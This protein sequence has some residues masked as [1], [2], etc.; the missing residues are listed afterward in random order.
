MKKT[1]LLLTTLLIL[2]LISNFTFASTYLG[3]L[4]SWKSNSDCIYHYTSSSIYVKTTNLSSSFTDFNLTYSTGISQ[5]SNAG[6]SVQYSNSLSDIDFYGGFYAQLKP[7][8][9]NLQYNHAGYTYP[10]SYYLEG[11]YNLYG[12]TLTKDCGYLI[13]NGKACVVQ[14]SAATANEYR[15]TGVHELGHAL[16][17]DGHSGT[18]SDVMYP[19]TD[20]SYTLTSSEKLH[21]TQ[22]Y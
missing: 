21:L 20:S 7:F 9:P 2:I 8:F 4:Y 11:Y 18:S 15:H 14:R 1:K 19:T 6:I 22:V 10:G 5:W 17:Y 3:V 12:T 13:G 16:G